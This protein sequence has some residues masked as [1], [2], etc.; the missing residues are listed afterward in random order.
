MCYVLYHDGQCAGA[1]VF[2]IGHVGW[3]SRYDLTATVTAG[4]ISKLVSRDLAPVLLQVVYS[5]NSLFVPFLCSSEV[6]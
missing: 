6:N 2:V 5:V 4:I 3:G 1:E